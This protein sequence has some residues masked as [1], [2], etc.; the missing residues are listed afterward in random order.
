MPERSIEEEEEDEEDGSSSQRSGNSS[1]K[2]R[3]R[4]WFPAGARHFDLV[5]GT[6][7]DTSPYAGDFEEGVESVVS[8]R[9]PA[10]AGGVD[11]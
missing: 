4:T 8:G 3:V 7:F 10:G 2:P 11:D 1:G 9:V 6:V 5:A